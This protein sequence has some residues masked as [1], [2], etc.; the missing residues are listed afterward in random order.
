[1]TVKIVYEF[2]NE[3]DAIA[4]LQGG[5]APVATGA[6]PAKRGRGRPPK[7]A[8]DPTPAAPSPAAPVAA[9]AAAATVAPAAPTPAPA[10]ST[11]STPAVP[12]KEVI[13]AVTA[14]AD[15]NGEHYETAKK[16]LGKYGA[17]TINQL[18][19]EF[20]GQVAAECKAAMPRPSATSLI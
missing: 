4:F 6:E 5:D 16:I 14:L 2:E 20:Y 3:A 1:M 17:A 7:A 19:P 9:P 15:L 12:V 11:A 10:P 18:K 13:D 8:A